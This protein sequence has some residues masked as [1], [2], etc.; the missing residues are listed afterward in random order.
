MVPV[1]RIT[2]GAA[3]MAAMWATPPITCWRPSTRE[4]T[5]TLST[6]FCRVTTPVAR[7]TSGFAACAALSVS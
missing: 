5:S 7:P 4:R 3:I 1:W 6:P 2:P